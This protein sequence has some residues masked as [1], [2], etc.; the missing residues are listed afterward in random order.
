MA[1]S[2]PCATAACLLVLDNFEHVL[3]AAADVAFLLESCPSLT[4]LV[5]SRAPLRV[6]GERRFQA[7]P[8]AL[9]APGETPTDDALVDYGAT[10]LFIERARAVRHNFA[11]D[12]ETASAIIEI[13]RRLDGLPLAIELA[14]AWFPVL[15]PVALLGK[16][17]R[18]LPLLRGGGTDQPA[19]FRTMRDAIAWSYDLLT[20]EEAPVLSP[21]QRLRRR[22]HA[23]GRRVGC[24]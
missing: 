3:A 17:E 5:T 15:T 11:L 18:R 20:A 13:C 6:S 8:L 16:L 24:R 23:G 10:A 4:T 7:P 12:T 1:L 9:P 2:R 14:A 22:L 19:R 21:S